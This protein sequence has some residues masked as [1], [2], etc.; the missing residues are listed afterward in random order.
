MKASSLGVLV[1]LVIAFTSCDAAASGIPVWSLEE[2]PKLPRDSP[3][4]AALQTQVITHSSQ[5]TQSQLTRM[6][7]QIERM[8]IQNARMENNMQNQ[9]ARMENN[10]QSQ[11]ARM[12][13]QIAR[14]ENNMQNQIARIG[15]NMQSQIARMEIQIARMEN[16]MQNQIARMENNMQ[17]QIARMEIQIAHMD[18]NT[19]SQ[20]ARMEIQIA[21][22][23][24]NT[25]SQMDQLF[26]MSAKAI[27]RQALAPGDPIEFQRTT[28]AALQSCMIPQTLG[29]FWSIS[30]QHAQVLCVQSG[31]SQT[32]Q[33]GEQRKAALARHLGLRMGDLSEV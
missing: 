33:S 6:E 26:L 4:W 24:N 11:I 10:M 1:L 22:M 2:G 20:I 5:Q 28:G 29:E 16:N 27:N 19:Q 32:L 14:M 23:E 15:N 18:N 13:I 30:A 9:I 25:Q 8:E 17:S 21:R 3:A 12:E 7:I 31:L